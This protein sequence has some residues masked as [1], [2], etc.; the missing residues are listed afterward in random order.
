MKALT[1]EECINTYG[2]C[3]N[4]SE[5][6]SIISVF[7]TPH[8]FNKLSIDIKTNT[9]MKKNENY[10]VKPLNEEEQRNVSGG[11]TQNGN[12]PIINPSTGLPDVSKEL[13]SLKDFTKWY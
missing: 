3:Y 11:L 7:V 6:T 9:I 10:M 12:R 5:E 8:T 2:G 13:D 1:L 4:Y